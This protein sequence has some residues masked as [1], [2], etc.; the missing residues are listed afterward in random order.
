M[1]DPALELQFGHLDR[2]LVMRNDFGQEGDFQLLALQPGQ[3]LTEVVGGRGGRIRLE[4]LHR[5]RVLGG[6][7]D[8]GTPRPVGQGR[9]GGP[10]QQGGRKNN[11]G[12]GGRSAAAKE[13]GGTHDDV[14]FPR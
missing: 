1:A 8:R 6:G 2:G 11:G 5:G 10:A 13:L 14:S 7:R 12:G 3:G 4:H 9:S